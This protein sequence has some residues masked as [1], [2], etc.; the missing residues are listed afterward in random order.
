MFKISQCP[1][2]SGT[3]FKGY[4]TCKDYTVSQKEFE[5]VQCNSC[6]F[7]FTDPRPEN[8][9]L[10]EYY[11]SDAYISHSDS[12]AGIVNKLYKIARSFTL[13]SK[14]ALVKPFA[15][16]KGLL[17]VGC[18]T[19]A[20]LNFC[21]SKDLVVDG[22]EPDEDARKF[23]Q[24]N[25]GILVHEEDQLKNW[26]AQKFSAI[27]MWHVLEHVPDLNE[28]IQELK[29]LLDN[30]GRL[31]VAV[32]NYTSGDAGRY[33]KYWAAYDVPRH[34]WHFSPKSIRTLF[35]KHGFV[36]ERTLPMKLDS[37]YVSMLSEKYK[38]GSSRLFSAVWT[39]LKSNLAAGDDKWSSQIYVFK[40]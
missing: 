8:K 4:L 13:K 39:G 14:Y 19:G 16:Q 37:F 6:D 32:P 3:E 22:V 36:L 38:N 15:E 29:N 30:K 18:G 1:V 26:E 31:F 33:G 9:D 2:C 20:F 17:D 21:A 11:K 10:G 28:R 25:H 12:S 5:I 24:N 23:V 7:V 40:K 27:T 34:L 35:N